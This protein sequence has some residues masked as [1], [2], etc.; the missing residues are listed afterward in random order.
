MRRRT[1]LAIAVALATALTLPAAG[2][3]PAGAASTFTFFGSGYG[4]GVGMSQW[5]AYGL[6]Q[7]GWTHTHIL[8]HFY[9]GTAVERRD[10]LPRTL[11]VEL[12][13]GR[14]LVHLR[15]QA[16][17]ARL[18]QGDPAKHVLVGE[19][20]EGR[21]WTVAAKDGG[22]AVRDAA[23]DLVGGRWWGSPSVPLTLT[24]ANVGS[25]MFIPEA[26]AIWG[27]GFSYARGTIAFGLYGCGNA[28]GC[29]ERVVAHVSLEQYLYGLGEVPASWPM[30]SMEAQAVAARSYAVHAIRHV[31]VRPDCDCH[32]TDG[33][34]DQTYIGYDREAGTDGGRWV[35]AVDATRSQVVIYG[36]EVI[37]AFYAASDGGH[38]D[39]VEDIWHGGNPAYAIPWLTGVCDPGESTTSNPWTDWTKSFDAATLTARLAPY[40]GSIGTI[41]GFGNVLRTGSARILSLRANGTGG[42]AAV[43]GAELKAGLG[44]YDDRVWI[45]SDRN[46]T[47]ALREKYD[48][49]GCGPGL[50]TSPRAAVEGGAQ[51]FFDRGGLYRNADRGLTVWLKGAIDLEYRAVGAGSGPLGVPMTT[52]RSLPTGRGRSCTDCRRVAF[53]GG[54]IYWKGSV[55]AHALWGAV[56]DAYLGVGGAG[57]AL[58]FPLTRVRTTTDGGR[59]AGF[60]HGRVLCPARSACGVT[61]R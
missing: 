28:G 18:W 52:A 6:A 47:G 5:G 10:T 7:M 41:T 58:G 57:G 9:Q 45:N 53:V 22:Y 48:G 3:G 13:Y 39:N 2:F 30:E 36:G 8:T 14:G 19:I 50:P 32:L 12:T 23:G 38:S 44:L 46:V 40:T 15:A 43:T 16:G 25:R 35:K 61:T 1:S 60:E 29:A 59:R 49:L 37:Q 51:Q 11:R 34:G 20:P 27:R 26:D 17:P 4:H 31:G 55:G 24:Y 21:T 42:S 33:S 54:R 56:L